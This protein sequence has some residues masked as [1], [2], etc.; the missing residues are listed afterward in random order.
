MPTW[1]RWFNNREEFINSNYYKN[2]NEFI[3]CKELDEILNKFNKKMLFCPHIGLLKYNDVFETKNKN[4]KIL[5]TKQEDIQELLIKGSV[6]ITDFSSIHTDFA[7]MSKPILY[8]QY[9]KEEFRK[10]HI[11]K[12]ASD[13]YFCYDTDGF[14]PVANSLQEILK[15][16]EELLKNNSKIDN[17]FLNR[18]QNFFEYFDD[19]NC[20]RIYKEIIKLDER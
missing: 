15:N 7:F 4:V 16:L 12:Q 11:G 10:K 1:R 18:I 2:I 5:E 19:K 3:N 8:Y 20:E 6:L 9:D 13:T 17:K 14:G